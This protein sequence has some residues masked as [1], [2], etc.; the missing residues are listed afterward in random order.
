LTP[1]ITATRRRIAD[2]GATSAQLKRRK[3]RSD[4]TQA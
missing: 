3:P 4:I 1:A 2:L